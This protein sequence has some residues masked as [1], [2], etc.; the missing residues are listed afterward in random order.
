MCFSRYCSL[1]R[2]IHSLA[3]PSR[4]NYRGGPHSYAKYQA[5]TNAKKL[6]QALNAR[7]ESVIIQVVLDGLAR[8]V[9][10]SRPPPNPIKPHPH[11][12]LGALCSFHE[13]L[14]LTR[15]PECSHSYFYLST[16]FQREST[17]CFNEL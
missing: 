8:S 3:R 11:F 7:K 13:G 16:R 2:L 5:K 10:S 9:Q 17:P 14:S 15:R 6:P 1:L 4:T 12:P